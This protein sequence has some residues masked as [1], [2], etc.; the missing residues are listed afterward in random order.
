MILLNVISDLNLVDEIKHK[1]GP[2]APGMQTQSLSHISKSKQ[3]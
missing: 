1:P 3:I 2:P